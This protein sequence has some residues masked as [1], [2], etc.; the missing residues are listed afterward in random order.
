MEKKKIKS[1]KYKRDRI[2]SGRSPHEMLRVQQ[3]KA[4]AKPR[5]LSV[6]TDENIIK[7]R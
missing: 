4:L 6:E 2:M 5:K 1:R 7:T 3:E